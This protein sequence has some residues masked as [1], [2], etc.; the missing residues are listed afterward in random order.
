MHCLYITAGGALEAEF[1][2]RSRIVCWTGSIR[3]FLAI[4]VAFCGA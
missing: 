4:V 3:S 1:D 2:V